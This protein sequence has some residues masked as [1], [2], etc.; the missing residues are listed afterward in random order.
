MPPWV[1]SITLNGIFYATWYCSSILLF[2]TLLAWNDSVQLQLLLISSS[3]VK[4]LPSL[5]LTVS[6][7][8]LLFANRW[9]SGW[10]CQVRGTSGLTAR[11]VWEHV[12]D[13]CSQWHH[14]EPRAVSKFLFF[15]PDYRMFLNNGSKKKNTFSV[16]FTETFNCIITVQSRQ[17]TTPLF[18]RLK[19]SFI[20]WSSVSL[21][22]GKTETNS[23]VEFAVLFLILRYLLLD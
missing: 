19:I 5:L 15:T 3:H 4:P 20:N 8:W 11:A 16:N 1:C 22:C 2:W 9:F 7:D 13:L 6:Y 18:L 23:N 10:T 21:S 14:T 17:W 12:E